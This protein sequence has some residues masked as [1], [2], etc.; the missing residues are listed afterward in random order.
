MQELRR[1]DESGAEILRCII[2]DDEAPARTL[3]REYLSAH[4]DMVLLAE[5]AN[6]FEAVK[7]VG[8]HSPDVIF[9]D[10]QMPKIDGFEVLEL[11]DSPPLVVFTTAYDE[12]AV[13]AFEVHAADYLLKPISRERFDDALDR[14]RTEKES[15]KPDHSTPLLAEVRRSRTP[16]QRILVRD[17]SRV[18]VI[19]AET[20]DY[21]EAQ[22]DYIAIHA[23]GKIHLKLERIALLEQ[24]LDPARFV[25]IHRS[26]ILNLERLARIE[27][28]AKDSRLA[29]LSDGT[30]LPL[31]RAGNDKLKGIIS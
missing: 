29:I 15:R 30:R 23:E 14:L 18:H 1:P 21:I 9:L 16:L 28:Y 8:E 6:G 13:R 26:F 12:Y 10:V 11:L 7:A 17:G 31:S 5:C 3:L 19:P 27:L 2:V 22:D 25:R 4:E 24:A 20:V